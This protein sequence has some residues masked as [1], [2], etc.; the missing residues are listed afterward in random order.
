MS[1]VVLHEWLTK[2][3]STVSNISAEGSGWVGKNTTLSSRNKFYEKR[4]WFRVFSLYIC[5]PYN[6]SSGNQAK[7]SLLSKSSVTGPQPGSISDC[8]LRHGVVWPCPSQ[9][10]KHV[11]FMDMIVSWLF[12]YVTIS[13][14]LSFSFF[15]IFYVYG[16]FTH[17][18][19]FGLPE[20]GVTNGW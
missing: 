3:V 15:K 12:F 4:W 7:G 11:Y 9:I 10:T 16:C 19:V 13:K 14:L 17:I 8:V 2:V 20:I 5:V 1:T 6:C 18:Y